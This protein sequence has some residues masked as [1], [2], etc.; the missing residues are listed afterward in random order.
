M[1]AGEEA[2]IDDVIERSPRAS[3]I[4][5]A[6]RRELPV[7]GASVRDIGSVDGEMGAAASSDGYGC[8]IDAWRRTQT[9]FGRLS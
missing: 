9:V 1:L 2:S 5:G 4:G 6:V 7:G 3:D 8:A